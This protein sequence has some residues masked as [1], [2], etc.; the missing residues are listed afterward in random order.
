MILLNETKSDNN[1]ACFLSPE[2][3]SLHVLLYAQ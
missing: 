1:E 2:T 3:D